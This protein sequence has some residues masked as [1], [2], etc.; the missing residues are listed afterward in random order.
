MAAFQAL[1]GKAYK[2]FLLKPM[3]IFA[4]FVFELGSLICGMC[5]LHS[6]F[7]HAGTAVRP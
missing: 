7:C 5:Y 3:F 6:T 4:V 2:Y 1:W